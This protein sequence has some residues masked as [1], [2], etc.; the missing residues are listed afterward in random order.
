MTN[1]NDDVTK[2]WV[3]LLTRTVD[4]VGRIVAV[5]SGC[6]R[7]DRLLEDTLP[8]A[9]PGEKED[10]NDR[11]RR[12]HSTV[13]SH[14]IRWINDVGLLHRARNLRNRILHEGVV[15]G[16]TEVVD[17]VL[18]LAD[19]ECFIRFDGDHFKYASRAC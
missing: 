19:A 17:R 7:L 10:M 18:G 15:P 12:A 1:G 2:A 5:V 9:P 6:A 16:H 13:R 11:I 4:D 3:Q 8:P 14:G